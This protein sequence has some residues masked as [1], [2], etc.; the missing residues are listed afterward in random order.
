[1]YLNLG[2]LQGVIK[3]EKFATFSSLWDF[4]YCHQHINGCNTCIYSKFECLNINYL[5]S[6]LN[7]QEFANYGLVITESFKLCVMDWEFSFTFGENK[8]NFFIGNARNNLASKRPSK[9]PVHDF[10]TDLHAETSM[11]AAKPCA[12]ADFCKMAL[13]CTK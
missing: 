8:G 7:I 5:H 11:S 9:I 4:D 12:F 1:M 10:V 13:L 2:P 3:V 6:Y